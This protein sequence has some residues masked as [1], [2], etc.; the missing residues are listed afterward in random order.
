MKLFAA[1][2]FLTLTAWG[3]CAM[4]F[5]TAESQSRARAEA[6]NKG[7]VIML[8]PVA[9]GTGL[10]GWLAYKRRAVTI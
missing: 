5:R 1:A 6:M 9:A 4:C 7:I 8:I 2:L 10:I 3:Q